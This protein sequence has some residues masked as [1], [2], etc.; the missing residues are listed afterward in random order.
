[1]DIFVRCT[2]Y[3]NT[4]TVLLM[5]ERLTNERLVHVGSTYFGRGGGGKVGF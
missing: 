2:H 1:M 5:N 4:Y 3:I